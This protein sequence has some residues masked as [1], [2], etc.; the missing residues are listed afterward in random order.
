MYALATDHLLY[1]KI[2][3]EPDGFKLRIWETPTVAASQYGD[4]LYILNV[5]VVSMAEARECLANHL[6][7][8]GGSLVCD[9]TELP[10]K[11]KIRLLA[12]P[13]WDGQS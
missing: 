5:R 6:T 3:P 8:N 9:Q 2:T 11:G 4:Y 7:L 12:F 1:Y 13:T 10:Y